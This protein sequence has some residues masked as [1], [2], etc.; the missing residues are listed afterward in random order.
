MKKFRVLAKKC[1]L[2]HHRDRV[3]IYDHLMVHGIMLGYDTWFCHGEPMYVQCSHK[4]VQVKQEIPRDT[5]MIRM[6]YNVFGVL[7]QN[8]DIDID[9]RDEA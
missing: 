3:K 5:T 8:V 6:L 1:V 2:Y 4:Y 7:G 9:R